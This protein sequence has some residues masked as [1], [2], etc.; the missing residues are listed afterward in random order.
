[1]EGKMKKMGVLCSMVFLGIIL[2]TTSKALAQ[3]N[4]DHKTGTVDT[5]AL[6]LPDVGYRV[7]L[8][9]VINY[10]PQIPILFPNGDFE[11]GPVIWEQ[12]SFTGW[13][14]IVQTFTPGVTPYDGVWSAA[15]G[16]NRGEV[17]YIGQHIPI[18]KNLPY[19]TYRHWIDSEGECGNA[20]GEVFVN[21]DLVQEYPLCYTN[22]TGGWVKRVVDLHAYAGNSAYIVIRA[23]CDIADYSYLFID[24]V[25]FESTPAEN[26]VA[27]K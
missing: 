21:W 14:L 27:I 5:I 7:Y 2:I 9:M 6:A 25:S 8:P 23:V 16:G 26:G 12:Y 22:N 24:H 17:S 4:P 15:L 11:Q 3:I 1:M 20:V 19:M 13:P 18:P 10:K